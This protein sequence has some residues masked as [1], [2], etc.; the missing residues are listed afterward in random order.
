MATMYSRIDAEPLATFDGDALIDQRARRPVMRIVDGVSTAIEW[1]E[2][3]L[4]LGRDAD[5]ND[6]LTLSGPEPDFH[7][8]A[9]VNDVVELA[10][11]LD[12]RFAVGFG[13][14]PAPVPHTRAVRLAGTST[15][16]ELAARVGYVPGHIG[17]P[18]PVQSVIEYTLGHAGIPAVGLWARVPH[19]AAAMPYPA[20][21]VA[22]L[23]GLE[24]VA[25]I[26]I[27]ADDLRAA[28]R[29]ARERIDALIANS[30]EHSE[31]VR[32]LERQSDEEQR[33]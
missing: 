33:S 23:E 14:F 22:L 3:E 4:S 19:Y 31:M 27:N 20:A 18:A 11:D 2:T 12:V 9:F 10:R 30:D 6:V 7:W 26:R 8:R 1:P 24:Q 16:A 21:A 29:G 15:S 13:A 28:A 32:E 17:V 5:G 25:G